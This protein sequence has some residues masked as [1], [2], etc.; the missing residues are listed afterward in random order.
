MNTLIVGGRGGI[1]QALLQHCA[2]SPDSDWLGATYFRAAVSSPNDIEASVE[3]ATVWHQLDVTDE[4]SVAELA[5]DLSTRDIKLHRLINT[6]G[7]LHTP[8]YGPEKSLRDINPEQY[9]ES[10]R[11]N[12]LPTLLLAKH[13]G[14]L[15]RHDDPAAFVSISARVGSITD[16]R[17]GGWYSYRASKAALNMSLKCIAVEWARTHRNVCVAALHPG[18]TDTALSQPFQQRLPPGQLQSAAWTAAALMAVIENLSA[19]QTGRFWA[20]DG[21]EIP[22]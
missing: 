18:T 4:A 19:S 14:P 20:F 5:A 13:L 11:V 22:W 10:Q 16:N 7:Y 21:A 17:L 12:A 2:E 8:T 15:L 6:V 3:S 1:G 9:L